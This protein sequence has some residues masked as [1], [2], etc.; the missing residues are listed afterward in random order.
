MEKISNDHNAVKVSDD[1]HNNPKHC[2]RSHSLRK[3]LIVD[4]K[5]G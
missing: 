1:N 5:L 2:P 4:F 3:L